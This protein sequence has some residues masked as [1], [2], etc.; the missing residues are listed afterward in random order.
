MDCASASERALRPGDVVGVK[1]PGEILATPDRGD[2]LE[3]VPFIKRQ[4][5]RTQGPGR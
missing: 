4:R 1:S 3:S 5:Q 2:A